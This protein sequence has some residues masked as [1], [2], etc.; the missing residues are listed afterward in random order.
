MNKS[1]SSFE[2]QRELFGLHI[3]F[4]TTRKVGEREWEPT[5]KSVVFAILSDPTFVIDRRYFDEDPPPPEEG[6]FD[7][8][9]DMEGFLDSVVFDTGP[10]V[11]NMEFLFKDERFR[12]VFE[13]ST[14]D[15]I[16]YGYYKDHLDQLQLSPD[17][18]M[19]AKAKRLAYNLLRLHFHPATQEAL[20]GELPP[21][22]EYGDHKT[23]ESLEAELHEIMKRHGF[24][25]DMFAPSTYR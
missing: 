9:N 12:Q 5:S 2:Q 6:D 11:T 17:S 19:D 8:W 18:P 22:N 16:N 23:L 24:T 13:S 25:P 20:H 7:M 14:W 1:T 3:H 4:I 21:W 15:E 10:D